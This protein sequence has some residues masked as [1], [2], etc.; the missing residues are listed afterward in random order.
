MKKNGSKE[1]YIYLD[2]DTEFSGSIETS[3]AYLEGRVSGT[4]LARK[5]LKLVSGSKAE[6]HIFTSKLYVEE[7]ASL[8]SK[9]FIEDSV[10]ALREIAEKLHQQESNSDTAVEGRPTQMVGMERLMEEAEE[11]AV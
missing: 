1:S 10:R 9:V 7:G 5:E 11:E 2:K 8:N 4:I 6:G 3:N